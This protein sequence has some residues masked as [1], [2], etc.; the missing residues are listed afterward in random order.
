MHTTEEVARPPVSPLLVLGAGLFAF[1]ISALLIRFAQEEAP[2]LVIAAWRTTMASLLLL[3]WALT[4]RRTELRGLGWREW[5]LALASGGM[6][7]VHFA[8]WISSLAY[9]SVINSTVLVATNPIWVALAA[10]FVL[11]E[12]L[13]RPL[14]IGIALAILGSVVITFSDA[15]L[16]VEGR[17]VGLDMAGGGGTWPL[18]GN[19]LAVV[20]ALTA[21]GYTLIG[22][23]LRPSLSLLSYITVVYS[24]ASLVLVAMVW[25]SGAS[26]WGYSGRAYI[27]FFLMALFPQL[28]GHTSINWALKFLPAAYV[29]IT[30]LGEPIGAS[31]LAFIVLRELPT[32]PWVALAG[33]VLIFG[34]I[35]L[36]SVWG[37]KE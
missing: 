34:G 5:G 28:I 7:G 8:S 23:C 27:L 22:R 20:G 18:L 37:G 25:L 16:V 15:L 6:L 13:S 1:S 21:A 35:L 36:A 9:T 24:A 4:Q 31:I 30:V 3:P 17:V 26:L 33:A 12:R 19:T 32:S 29:S 14:K 2:S 11:H 10:P